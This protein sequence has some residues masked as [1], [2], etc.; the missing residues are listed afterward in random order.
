M[1]KQRRHINVTK[2]RIT[3]CQLGKHQLI[4]LL[5]RFV[6]LPLYINKFYFTFGWRNNWSRDLIR[7]LEHL[8]AKHVAIS[9]VIQATLLI[10]VTKSR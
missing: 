5:H 8:L 1:G 3:H 9:S 7:L 10:T 4:T 2:A 6:S